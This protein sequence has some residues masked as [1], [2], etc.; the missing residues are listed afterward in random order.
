MEQTV[1]TRSCGLLQRG[2]V[3]SWKFWWISEEPESQQ[4][5]VWQYRLSIKFFN[6]DDSTF[7]KN[8]RRKIRL[9]PWQTKEILLVESLSK[10]TKEDVKSFYTFM[11]TPLTNTSP[12][13]LCS[14]ILLPTKTPDIKHGRGHACTL[15][16][17][18]MNIEI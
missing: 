6:Q 5:V 12:R 10:E 2:V 15:A 7:S 9:R 3:A 16:M 14:I 8:F 17:E 4:Y 18:A 11:A 13:G 1:Q